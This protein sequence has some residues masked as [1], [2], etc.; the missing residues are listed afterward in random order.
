MCNGVVG[1]A[2]GQERG[3]DGKGGRGQRGMKG[4]V[5]RMKTTQRESERSI[6]YIVFVHP[7]FFFGGGWQ[8]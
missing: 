7:I 4:G 8:V 6:G 3:G 5:G 2:G 1:M